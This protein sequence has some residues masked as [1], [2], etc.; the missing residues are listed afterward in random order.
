MEPPALQPET[1]WKIDLAEDPSD[2]RNRFVACMVNVDLFGFTVWE[3]K[4]IPNF[5]PR[6]F[7]IVSVER[8]Y[9]EVVETC[10]RRAA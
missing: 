9:V 2:P 5:K 4:A 6:D 7:P 10:P 1:S 8:V 3:A